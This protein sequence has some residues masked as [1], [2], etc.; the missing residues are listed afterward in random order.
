MALYL[1]IPR[2]IDE[3]DRLLETHELRST[4]ALP[5]R[6]DHATPKEREVWQGIMDGLSNK[7][8]AI[9]LSRTERTVKFHV[10][11]LLKLTGCKNRFELFR[12]SMQENREEKKK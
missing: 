11:R 1:A 2:K 5:R 9:R 3:I 12:L 8:I 6:S 7:A 10:S 4:H